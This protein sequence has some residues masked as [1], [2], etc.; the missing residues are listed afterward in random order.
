MAE[1]VGQFEEACSNVE[2]E[3]ED[4][5]NAASAHT[6]VREQLESD[7]G[8]C[9]AG[10]D[11]VLIGSYKR[12]VSIRRVKDVDV[13]SKM[14]DID[15]DMKG[16]EA[17][18]VVES[19][20]REAYE[21]EDT[22]HERVERQDRSVKVE[23]PDYDLH[24]DVVPARPA[25]AYWEIPDRDGGWQLT[26]PEELTELTS[27]MNARTAYKGLYV[28]IVKLVRQ[29]RREALGVEK[30]GGLFFEILTHHAFD[31]GLGGSNLPT[32]YVAALRSIA[33]QLTK[34]ANGDNVTDPTMAGA[35]MKIRATESQKASAASKFAAIADKAEAA[36][37]ESELCKAAKSFQEILGRNADGDWVFLMPDYCNADGTP[38]EKK[39]AGDRSIP[40]G[41]RRFA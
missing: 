4:K 18:D 1:L 30:P 32:L 23:F 29:T 34:F 35:V 21:D 11:T 31:G 40:A 8:L 13:F 22:D 36:H 17:L 2:P 27:K 33:G 12:N 16:A 25:G 3:D 24:V 10:I 26:N 5:E 41:N 19:V 37:A 15:P 20:L 38:K 9:D 14:P 28:P 7:S 6:D 39:T